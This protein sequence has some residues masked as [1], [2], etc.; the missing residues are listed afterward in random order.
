M[1]YRPEFPVFQLAALP[2]DV[3]A[4]QVDVLPAQRR[5]VLIQVGI[6]RLPGVGQPLGCPLQ[7]G[8]VPQQNGGRHHVE[9]TG[10]VALLLETPILDFTEVVEEHRPGWPGNCAPRP[11]SGP[12]AHGG[13]ARHFAASPG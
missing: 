13:A 7:V 1:P 9:A 8:R 12:H 5:Q 2:P 11:C 4:C 6:H 10:P 3:I